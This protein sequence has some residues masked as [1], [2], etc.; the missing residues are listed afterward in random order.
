MMKA[1]KGVSARLLMKEFAPTLKK[2]L[3]DGHLWNPSY[4][5]ATISENRE[6]QMIKYIQKQKVKRGDNYDRE[7]K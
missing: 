5:V 4:F 7:S 1:M 6:E 2:K 3:R